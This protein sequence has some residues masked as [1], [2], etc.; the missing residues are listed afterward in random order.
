MNDQFNWDKVE[1]GFIFSWILGI[2][3]PHLIVTHDYDD[4]GDYNN[5]GN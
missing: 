2:A 1:I 5:D 4:I 3:C